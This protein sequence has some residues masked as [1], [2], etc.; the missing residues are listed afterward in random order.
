MNK[1]IKNI[2][3]TVYLLFVVYQMIHKQSFIHEGVSFMSPKK[4]DSCLASATF[5]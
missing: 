1:Q 5:H 3:E 4:C 2:F